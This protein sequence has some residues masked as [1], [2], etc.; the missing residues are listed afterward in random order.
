ML[1]KENV[2]HFVKEWQ[3][4]KEEIRQAVET[5]MNKVFGGNM[6]P[7]EGKIENHSSDSLKEYYLGLAHNDEKAQRLQQAKIESI[8]KLDLE[9][10]CKDIDE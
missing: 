9:Q 10:I 4:K 1:N 5:S 2:F 7:N 8:K 3:I 6:R